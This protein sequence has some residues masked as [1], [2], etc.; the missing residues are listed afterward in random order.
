[1]PIPE[2]ETL[3]SAIIVTSLVGAG[4][5]QEAHILQDLLAS[6][7]VQSTLV[8]YTDQNKAL[9]P[10]DITISLEVVMPRVFGLARRHYLLPN[11]EWWVPQN[12]RYLPQFTKILCKT[13]HCYDVW[14]RK[15]GPERCVYTSF[16]ARDLYDPRIERQSAFLHV[17]GHSSAKN[18]VAVVKAWHE[19]ANLPSL[20]V[21]CDNA[22]MIPLLRQPSSGSPVYHVR[23]AQE[24]ELK[25]FMNSHCY[26]IMP[27]A[28]EG[29][30]HALHEGIGCDAQVFTTDAPPMN[31]YKGVV[32]YFI[33]VSE[34]SPRC[35]VQ[36]SKITPAGVYD[37][38]MKWL[39]LPLPL[40]PRFHFLEN[41]DF[42]RQAFWQAIQ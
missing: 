17:A 8:H 29:F 26:H 14:S 36:T 22:E 41:R 7:G 37:T 4:L 42:F 3:K 18:T 15:V 6:H 19:H 24:L 1:M 35:L 23:R 31:Q 32:P 21:V 13:E 25:H 20:T 33:P 30:G 34:R 38:V 39:N 27:S 12:E 9:F 16:E 5:E 11:S 28:Y 10:A 2:E 40:A